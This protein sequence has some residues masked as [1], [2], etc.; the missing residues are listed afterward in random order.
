MAPSCST[1][2][3][4]CSHGRRR[5]ARR[6]NSSSALAGPI[7]M[8]SVEIAAIGRREST[9]DNSGGAGQGLPVN[10]VASQTFT[11]DSSAEE[12]PLGLRSTAERSRAPSG[13]NAIPCSVGFA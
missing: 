6:D 7:L 3:L 9:R 12:M 2:A 8:H 10:G 4:S 5:V 13:E 11:S 1:F